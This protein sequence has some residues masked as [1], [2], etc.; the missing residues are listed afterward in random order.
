MRVP[1]NREPEIVESSE[2]IKK[3]PQG[4][5]ESEERR[6]ILGR[7]L[8]LLVQQGWRVEWQTDHQA[9]MVRG[10]RVNHLLHLIL[11]LITVGWWT[12]VWILI[13]IFGGE[14]RQMVNVDEFG[15]VSMQK[16]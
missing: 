16:A 1:D 3:D 8:A 4:Y 2:G 14:K 7:H 9:I 11:T 13:A 12:I 6:N 10:N 5:V 15:N